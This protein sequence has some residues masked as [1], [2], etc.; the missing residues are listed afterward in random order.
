MHNSSVPERGGQHRGAVAYPN[1][2]EIQTQVVLAN[3]YWK[4]LG[5]LVRTVEHLFLRLTAL[6]YM[7][8]MALCI[9]RQI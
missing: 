4:E 6:A 5:H 9:S 8:L 1:P 7:E 3:G 2:T